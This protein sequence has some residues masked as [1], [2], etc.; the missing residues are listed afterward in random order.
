MTEQPRYTEADPAD[1][2]PNPWNTNVVPPENEAKIDASLKRFG[3]FKPILVRTLP[4]GALQILGGEH[5]KDSAIRLGMKSVPVFNLGVI[6]DERAQEIGLVDNGRYGHDDAVKLAVLLD[7]LGGAAELEE[8][9]PFSAED[10]ESIFSATVAIDDLELPAD[11]GGAT[12]SPLKEAVAKTHTIMRFK[13]PVGDVEVI[14]EKIEK[15]M[16]RQGFTEEDSLANAGNALVHLLTAG[17][18]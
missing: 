15:V 16:K 1:L 5:R 4:D 8:F 6:S 3:M 11:T 7:G 9:M 12:P 10:M 18:S 17:E 14:S 13:V 2:K